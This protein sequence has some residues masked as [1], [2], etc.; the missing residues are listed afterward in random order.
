MATSED[1]R[2]A[3]LGERVR[4][5]RKEI[6]GSIE[7]LARQAGLSATSWRRV[8]P[9]HLSARSQTYHAIERV[10]GW[11]HGGIARFLASGDEPVVEDTTGP[12]GDDDV[13][14]PRIRQATVDELLDEVR[15]RVHRMR[16]RE[17]EQ[18]VPRA[19]APAP[20]HAVDSDGPDTDDE[21]A[22][23][24]TS[25]PPREAEVSPESGNRTGG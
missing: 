8:E 22:V 18:A 10:L 5:R 17:A 4:A 6:R 2:L 13:E 15:A 7:G 19:A 12:A 23:P 21:D 11:Q 3:A 1:E 14:N 25:R 16:R 24:G 9:N 20:L